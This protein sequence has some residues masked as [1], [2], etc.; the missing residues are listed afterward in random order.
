[1]ADASLTINRARAMACKLAEIIALRYAESAAAYMK[2]AG[3]LTLAACRRS[4]GRPFVICVASTTPSSATVSTLLAY[5]DDLTSWE[6]D[7]LGKLSLFVDDCCSCAWHACDGKAA[8][9]AAKGA[10]Q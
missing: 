7:M 8:P 6:A 3:A 9:S 1:M 5:Q 10:A 4:C 2:D